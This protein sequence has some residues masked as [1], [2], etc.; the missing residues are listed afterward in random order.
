MNVRSKEL[1]GWREATQSGESAHS[2]QR[3]QLEP[4]AAIGQPIPRVDGPAKVAGAA[5]FTAD[6]SLPDLAYASLVLST[7][8]RGRI[9]ELDVGAAER[10]AGVI[11]V[12]TYQNAPRMKTPTD[13]FADRK[14]AA[15]SNLPVMQDPGISW[16]GQPVAVVIAE[17]Q[18]EADAAARDVGVSYAREHAALSFAQARSRAHYPDKILG[19]P[20]R[21]CGGGAEEALRNAPVHVDH[22]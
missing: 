18:E 1:Q 21:I 10:A 5:A 12:M 6:V 20:A 13:M 11:A 2:E 17:T 7:I 22:T 15:V 4:A 16:N 19:E 14:S 8:A 9:T 3:K